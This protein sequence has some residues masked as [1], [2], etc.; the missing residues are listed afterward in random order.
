VK[1]TIHMTRRFGSTRNTPLRK[2][3]EDSSLARS[4]GS[5]S[6]EQN[7]AKSPDK[8]CSVHQ[9]WQQLKI[10]GFDH[11]K[12]GEGRNVNISIS[13]KKIMLSGNYSQHHVVYSRNRHR[14][15]FFH[16]QGLHIFASTLSDFR[17]SIRL[18]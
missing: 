11:S 14:F 13:S 15:V 18:A 7:A 5:A 1:A 10:D 8:A 6:D 9:N 3:A 4:Y 2:I 16:I 17:R 12:S